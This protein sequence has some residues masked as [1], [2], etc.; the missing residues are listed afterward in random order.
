MATPESSTKRKRVC[1]WLDAKT[2][3]Q[4]EAIKEQTGVMKAHQLRRALRMWVESCRQPVS[5]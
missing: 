2:I 4:L 3:N 5:R 1:F